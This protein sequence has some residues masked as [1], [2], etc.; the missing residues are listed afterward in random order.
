M[1]KRVYYNCCPAYFRA[2]YLPWIKNKKQ[3]L[4]NYQKTYDFTMI[5]GYVFINHI[6]PFEAA[7]ISAALFLCR[8]INFE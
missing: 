3:F 2:I 8:P 6:Q 4:M 5:F 1:E 7:N